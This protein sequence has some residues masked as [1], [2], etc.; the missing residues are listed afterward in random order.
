MCG[1]ILARSHC[2]DEAMSRALAKM[3]YRGDGEPGHTTIE[4]MG[5]WKIGHL[6]LAIQDRSAG[7]NQPFVYGNCLTAFVGEIFNH[8]EVSEQGFIGRAAKAPFLF[9]KADGFW[10]VVQTDGLTANAFT[11]HLGIKPLYYWPKQQIVCSEIEPM[12]ELAP[13]PYLDE[14]YLSNCIKFGYD[15]SGRTPY[16]GIVQLAPG[17]RLELGRTYVGEI[18]PYWNWFRVPSDGLSLRETIQKAI[19]N[20]LIGER[21]VA[22]LLSGGLDSSI[23]YYTLKGFVQVEAFSVENGESEF[24][25]EDVTPLKVDPVTSTEALQVLKAPLDL[26]SMIPQV[27]L[28]RAVAS[29]GYNICLTGDGADEVFGGYRRALEY[30]SQASDVFCEL[31]YYHLPRLDRAMMASTVELRSPYL[32]PEVI[33]Y[34]LRLPYQYR[35]Q[36]EALKHAFSGVVPDRII[37]RSKHP[38]KSTAVKE[39]GLPYRRE[40]VEQFR[41]IYRGERR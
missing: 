40:L 19:Y 8:D 12:F 16:E 7:G 17:R 2:S 23:I 3:S 11:D 29:A 4:A 21:P 26:G 31:P 20:R 38:L 30:D 5:G 25:P 36:K 1:L 10:A 32:A 9:H 6:R 14:T 34:G 28:A 15:Y 24:L 13:R 35:T 18:H 27:Q 39:G 37:N 22:L 33:A 41:K